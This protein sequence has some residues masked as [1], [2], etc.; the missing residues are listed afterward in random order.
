MTNILVTKTFLS[1]RRELVMSRESNKGVQMVLGSSLCCVKQVWRD[2]FLQSSS[3]NKAACLRFAFPGTVSFR[4]TPQKHTKESRRA[5]GQ[6]EFIFSSQQPLQTVCGASK[7]V[8]VC[9]SNSRHIR[10]QTHMTA[11]WNIKGSPLVIKS[12]THQQI[13]FFFT[14]GAELTKRNVTSLVVFQYQCETCWV[15]CD[16]RWR[17]KRM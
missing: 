5:A 11:S 6:W 1:I 4:L 3:A 10:W 12:F 2:I 14:W 17:C 13:C 7:A 15:S 8:A 9:G 16:N